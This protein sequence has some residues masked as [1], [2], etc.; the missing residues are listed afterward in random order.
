MTTNDRR[1]AMKGVSKRL[2]EVI[3]I[4]RHLQQHGLDD[5]AGVVDLRVDMNEFVRS[6]DDK[7]GRGVLEDGRVIYWHLSTTQT[8][9]VHVMKAGEG[10]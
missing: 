5:D 2:D 10:V 4:R 3:N 6:G 7:I 8:C 9:H 1:A